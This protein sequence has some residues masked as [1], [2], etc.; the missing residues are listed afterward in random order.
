MQFRH[1]IPGPS[2]AADES[3]RLG[4]GQ[5]FGKLRAGAGARGARLE[6]VVLYAYK[7]RE[8]V[9]LRAYKRRG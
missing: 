2:A 7:K 8:N 9:G 3:F 4:S 5:V 6:L 1:S